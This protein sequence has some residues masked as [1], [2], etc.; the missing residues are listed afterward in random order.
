MMEVI[1]H[2]HPLKLTDLQVNVEDV[3][4]ESDDDE[5][6]V[7]DLV[8]QDEFSCT[9]KRYDG[10]INEYYRYYYKCID[11]S[12]DFTLHKFCA[13]LP[14]T[15]K[16]S[17]HPHP[18]TLRNAPDDNWRCD[19]CQRDHKGGAFYACID[20][21]WLKKDVNCV[22]EVDKRRIY[23]PSHPHPLV[24]IKAS[25][26]NVPHVLTSP[27]TTIY[28]AFLPKRLL[29]RKT[30]NAIFNHTHP[31]SLSYS[32][33]IEEFGAKHYPRC[34]VCDGRFDF[35]WDLLGGGP[36]IK[37]YKDV[38][39]PNLLHIPFPDQTYS[40]PK[41]L[42][43]KELGPTDYGNH[44]VSLRHMNHQHELIL[45]DTAGS[46]GSTSSKIMCHN[47]MKKIEL[48]L[49]SGC[50]RPIM[51]MPFYKCRAKEDE[52]CNFVLHEWCTWLPTKVDNHPGHPQHPL[53]L[54]TN[55]PNMFNLFHCG[56][57]LL[58]CN[59]FAYGC[60]E[61]GFYVDVPCGFMPERI[62]HESHPNHLLSITE[63]RPSGSCLMCRLYVSPYKLNFCCSF[64]DVAL[65]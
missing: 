25:S 26:F 58:P 57:C 20:C 12:C 32:F 34:R 21:Y 43:L 55:I 49:C 24:N 59:G 60:V 14:E 63:D 53:L 29:I 48:L 15:L 35:M 3:D 51:E 6:K 7:E 52:N 47:P 62:T 17:T 44:E 45:V 46:I 56:V 4:D 19:S 61:C 5:E 10:D 42:F 36:T 65:I 8:P 30:T 28:C 54:M 64:C 13:E 2:E 41:H 23:H 38:D 1:E 37:N 27:Y 50:V 9:C 40:I 31:L 11:D 22:V 33:P 18:F 39:Y 16:H